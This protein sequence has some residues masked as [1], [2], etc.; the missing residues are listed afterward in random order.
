VSDEH[1]PP[2]FY[3]LFDRKIEI[4]VVLAAS[5]NSQKSLLNMK[6]ATSEH[7]LPDSALAL[8]C[9]GPL[10]HH[11]APHASGLS[12]KYVLPFFKEPP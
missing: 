9:P 1:I 3:E 4:Y 2:L 5:S 7:T 10:L 8:F 11:P 12:E 6:P